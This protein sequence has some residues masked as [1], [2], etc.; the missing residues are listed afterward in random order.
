MKIRKFVGL[1]GVSKNENRLARS[2]GKR[3]EFAMILVAIW[4][5]FQWYLEFKRHLPID[6][7]HISNW[8]VWLVL[9]SEPTTLLFL[10]T[11]KKYYL[12][13]NWLNWVIIVAAF[14]FI[15]GHTSLFASLRVLQLVIMLRA[16][17]PGWYSLVASYRATA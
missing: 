10:V 12:R 2:W 4:I 16:L 3:F 8:L 7:I 13:R 11:R 1:A 14:P 5:P 17:L 6:F 9:L 15:S